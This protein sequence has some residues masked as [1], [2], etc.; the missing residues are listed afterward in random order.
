MTHWFQKSLTSQASSASVGDAYVTKLGSIKCSEV[1][2]HL[3][4]WTL[5][6]VAPQT[7]NTNMVNF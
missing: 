6:C 1:K 5:G 7:Q 3:Q 2:S 4:D